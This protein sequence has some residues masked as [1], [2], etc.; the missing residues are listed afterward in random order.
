MET[1]KIVNLLNDSHNESSKFATRKWYII[2]EQ[3]S[4]QY[5]NRDENVSTIKFET[6]V[7]KASLC[8]YSDA[9]VL[10]TLNIKVTG[11]NVDIKVTFKSSAPFRR[12][13][14]HRNDEDV[15]TTENLDIIMSMYNLIEYTD[16]YSDSSGR[17][18]QF[19]RDESPKNDAG[20][21]INVAMDN[22]TSF[23]HKASFLVKAT[24]TDH[25]RSLIDVKIDLPLKYLFNF[26]RSL[27]MPLSN[28]KSHLELSWTKDCVMYGHNTYADGDND[29]N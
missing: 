6:K 28:C 20:N 19:K 8:D 22:S 21:S 29:N 24:G 3:N 25:D 2:N 16:N 11:V 4:R 26:F 14:T 18:L 5:G 1:Q 12:C 17:L 27:K 10:V 7:I 15:E 9:H 13:V 23:K